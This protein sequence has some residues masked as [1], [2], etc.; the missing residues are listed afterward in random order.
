MHNTRK[1]FTATSTRPRTP[2]TLLGKLLAASVDESVHR[3]ADNDDMGILD[4]IRE[5]LRHLTVP[6]TGTLAIASPWAPQSHLAPVI[7]AD[8]LGTLPRRVTREQAIQIPAL[9][10]ARQL[11]VSTIPRLPL[12]ATQGDTDTD[13]PTWLTSSIGA[14]SPFHR[15]L[16]T[17]D[18]LFFYGW[19]LWA[20]D[21][22]ADGAIVAAARVPYDQWQFTDAGEVKIN[23]T[24]AAEDEVMLIPG[25][26]EGI[27]Q[28]G[29]ATLSEAINLANAVQRA[30]ETPNANIE[31]HQTND[32]PMT[33]EQV[34]ELIA[35]WA[36]ARRG[37]NGGVAYTSNGIEVREHGAAMEHLLIQG[38]NA[39]AVDVARHAGIPA[40]M[41]DATLSG[42]SISY[43]NTSARMSELITFG[44]S[45]ILS[46]VAAR[47]SQDDITPPG[48]QINFDATSVIES[49]RPLDMNDDTLDERKTP[50]E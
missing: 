33:Q 4:R 44:L 22:D 24:V 29:A 23:D 32:A 16:W 43:Q 10:R 34:R 35:G 31:L 9:S 30:A 47:L 6:A 28:F 13:V 26:G 19:A 2:A 42:S 50:N 27:L 46:A 49:L 12:T 45:P 11:I 5:P 15:M 14:L 36:K 7:H 8:I 37:E 3:P 17:V 39:V 41:I 38:R 1:R 48:M 21:R 20:L 40:T 25:I 18:D